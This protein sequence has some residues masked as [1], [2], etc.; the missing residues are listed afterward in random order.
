MAA[1][2]CSDHERCNRQDAIEKPEREPYIIIREGTAARNLEALE[3]AK[4]ETHAL[5]INPGIDPFITLRFIAL[6]VI[7]ALRITTRGVFDVRK[8]IYL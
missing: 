7:P 2:V 3:S 1:W 4:T 5:G 8:Q 6:A